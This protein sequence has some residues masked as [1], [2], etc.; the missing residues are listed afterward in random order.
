MIL[1]DKLKIKLS[2]V[3]VKVL[4]SKYKS[5][6]KG[7]MLEIKVEDLSNGSHKKI[8]VKCDMCGKEKFIP[9]NKYLKNFNNGGFYSCSQKCSSTKN[10]DTYFRRTGF[11]HQMKDPKIKDKISR[12]NIEKYGFE[13]AKQ[14][15]DI[16]QKAIDTCIR[17]NGVKY[18][19]LLDKSK[20]TMMQKYGVDNAMKN[21]DIL[22]KSQITNLLKYG[23]KTTLLNKDVK[24]KSDE[25][26][27]LLYGTTHPLQNKEI[28]EK[29]IRNSFKYETHDNGIIYQGTYEKD[30]LDICVKNNIKLERG[31][32]I[33]YKLNNDDLIYFS[34]FFIKDLNLIIEVKSSWIWNKHIDK[35][36]MKIESCLEQGFNY[37]LIMDK[38]YEDF[39]ISIRYSKLFEM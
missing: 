2:G 17:N 7:E 30:F 36:L 15:D 5:I 32:T 12:T 11:T 28:M 25:K 3:D 26:M 23:V 27:I 9:Y 1:T 4:K 39:K 38:K 20:E 16:K 37:I 31:L 19:F 21:K 22:N 8:E 35:N 24:R 29:M 13:H 18:G 10:S 33:K 34:D 14:N 6:K